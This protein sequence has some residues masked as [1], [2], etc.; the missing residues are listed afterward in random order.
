MFTVTTQPADEKGRVGLGPRFANKTV[1][2]EEI[3]ETEVRVT[4]AALVPELELWLRQ[5][6]CAKATVERGLAQAKKRK[7][8]KNP[9]NPA[10]DAALAEKFGN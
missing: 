8:S 6:A 1:N 3:D 9:P 4:I 7:F 10:S 5:N 2:I